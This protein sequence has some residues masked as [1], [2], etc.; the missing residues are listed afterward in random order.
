M[1]RKTKGDAVTPTEEES[2]FERFEK[3]ARRIVNVPRKD[4]PPPVRTPRQKTTAPIRHP[5]P[6]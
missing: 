4:V 5:E 6:G 3:L 2:E 1:S